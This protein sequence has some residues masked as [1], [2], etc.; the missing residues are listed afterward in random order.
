M[1]IQIT[2]LLL[3]VIQYGPVTLPN[4]GNSTLSKFEINS[5]NESSPELSRF[6]CTIFTVEYNGSIYFGG[7][8]DEGGLRKNTEVRFIP[9][10][11]ETTYGMALF[12]FVDNEVGGNDVDGIGISGINEKGLCFDANGLLP[13]KYVDSDIGGQSFSNLIFWEFILSKC[14]SVSEVIDWYQTHN[15]GGW[16]GNQIHWADSTGAAVVIGANGTV[17]FTEKAHEKSFLISTNFNLADYSHGSFP[18]W[19]YTT[20]TDLLDH[21]V[22]LN[23]VTIDNLKSTLDNVHL[24]GTSAYIGTA[25]SHI[26]N[27][28]TCEMYIYILGNYDEVLHLDLAE[29]LDKGKHSYRLTDDLISSFSPKTSPSFKL[30]PIFLWIIPIAYWKRN[31][32]TSN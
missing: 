23:D 9:T 26:F 25:Y 12:G 15:M 27:L 20:V 1:K 13:I 11:D 6:S 17:A 4:Y 30:L 3:L 22:G 14:A 24:I 8:E 32:N 18:C 28:N 21:Y 16:W 10:E 19:R 7:N 5:V 29:E 2:L 31:K